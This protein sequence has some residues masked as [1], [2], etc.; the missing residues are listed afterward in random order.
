MNKEL[1][2]IRKK[3]YKQNETINKNKLQKHTKII[4]V[5]KIATTKLK[6]SVKGFNS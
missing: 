3:M 6:N 5:L 2:E 1:K 4:L